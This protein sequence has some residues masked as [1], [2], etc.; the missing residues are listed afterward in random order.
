MDRIG[1]SRMP[2]TMVPSGTRFRYGAMST[3]SLRSKGFRA[4]SACPECPSSV[5][6]GIGFA[7]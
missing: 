7:A 1:I 2:P 3:A 5:R 6:R 4:F